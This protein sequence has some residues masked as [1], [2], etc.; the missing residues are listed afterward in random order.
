M[1]AFEYA[2]PGTKEEAV[3]LLAEAGA[4]ARVLAG[5]TDLLALMKERIATP[6]LLVSLRDV[7][8][9]RGV[10]YDEQ[11]GWQI[12]AAATLDELYRQAQTH[13]LYSAVKHAIEGIHS[14]QIRNMGTVGGELLQHPRCWYYRAGYGLLAHRDG[15]SLVRDGDNRY[16]AIF[17]NEAAAAY[18]SASS[19]APALAALGAT[20]RLFGPQGERV[21]PV[22]RLFRTPQQ[23]GESPF[24][25]GADEILTHVL[26]PPTGKH[27]NATY[28]V[29][30]REALE[31]PLAAA[32]VYLPT[33]AASRVTA[34]A[35]IVLGHVAPVPWSVPAAARTLEGQPLNAETAA[36]AARAAVE[37]A[38]PLSRNAYK[39][40]LAEVA[41]KRAILRSA[42]TEV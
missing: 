17:G 4:E 42:G 19:L 32:A 13:E 22:E 21:L 34:G 5:G 40:R 2:R 37:G 30:Q 38:R 20:V 11:A 18:V 25:L 29:R 26:V 27:P 28:E 36:V 15:R 24:D 6:R 33:D 14:P 16:H 3:R 35:R 41:V 9:L 1:Q 23:D 10:G 12:G 39:V 7:A 8:E 31:W